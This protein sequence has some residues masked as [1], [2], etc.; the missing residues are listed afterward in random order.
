MCMRK[1]YHPIGIYGGML[2]VLLFVGAIGAG[3]AATS[4]QAECP[5]DSDFNSSAM[6]WVSYSGTWYYN[7]EY[8]FTYG[9]ADSWSSASH[10]GDFNNFDYQARMWRS[11]CETC[12]NSIIFRGTP[13]PLTATNNWYNEY[14]LQYTRD[15]YYSVW[16]RTAGGSAVPIVSWTYSA[17]IN[18]GDA[19]N[20]LRVVADGSNLTFY[21]NGVQLW[22]GTD[23]SL[24]NGQA[25]LGMYRSASSTGDELR[26]DWA[27]LCYNGMFH[28]IPNGKGGAA[29]IYLR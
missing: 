22:S 24:S 26:V 17:A 28:I 25:G 11:G 4:A 6:H 3:P 1:M 13:Y 5:I 18:Q 9:L 12:A 14:K 8:L 19:W 10:A 23:S 21:I 20:T 27:R 29:V 7:N 2:L 16:K 15:G